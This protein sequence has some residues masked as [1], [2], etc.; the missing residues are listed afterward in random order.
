MAFNLPTAGDRFIPELHVRPWKAV[1]GYTTPLEGHLVKQDTSGNRLI[2]QCADGDVPLGMILRDN[3]NGVY[4]VW[5]FRAGATVVLQYSSTFAVGD[6]IVS[7]AAAGTIAVQGKLRDQIKHDNT[8]GIGTV[9][10][11]DS[12]ATGLCEVAF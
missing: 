12:P 6:K 2:N 11:K 8:N 5:E 10:A 9:T 1:S 7:H 3:G 4:S